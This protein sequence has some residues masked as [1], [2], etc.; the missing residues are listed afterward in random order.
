MQISPAR[1]CFY[2]KHRH[3]NGGKKKKNI[4]IVHFEESLSLN[5]K[6]VAST[7]FSILLEDL[8]LEVRSYCTV[9]EKIRY[10]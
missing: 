8:Y 7:L 2:T 1:V 5:S 6:A 10:C 9:L 4:D 3:I